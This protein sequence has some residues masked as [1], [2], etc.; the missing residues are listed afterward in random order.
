MQYYAPAANPRRPRLIKRLVPTPEEK[1]EML[2]GDEDK[3]SKGHNVIWREEYK[4]MMRL[5]GRKKQKQREER[6]RREAERLRSLE[7]LGRDNNKPGA[8]GLGTTPLK[9]ALRKD[10]RP[11][12]REM[13]SPSANIR[14]KAN[15]LSTTTAITFGN[16]TTSNNNSDPRNIMAENNLAGNDIEDE[17]NGNDLEDK[18]NDTT[19]AMSITKKPTLSAEALEAFKNRFEHQDKNKTRIAKEFARSARAESL[20]LSQELQLPKTSFQNGVF[21]SRDF[22]KTEL[23]DDVIA[24]KTWKGEFVAKRYN[25]IVSITF[26]DENI[27]NKMSN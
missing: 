10:T 5:G 19:E 23:L 14:K 4:E 9:S 27:C 20:R 7:L 17:K 3:L 11:L 6:A 24:K 12:S 18:L 26:C 2:M 16:V 21:Q 13:S 22:K 25:R 8:G 1:E 15:T